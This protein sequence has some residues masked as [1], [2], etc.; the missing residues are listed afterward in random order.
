MYLL[1]SCHRNSIKNISK[2]AGKALAG[3]A[4][5]LVGMSGGLVIATETAEAAVQCVG[6]P[7]THI[8]GGGETW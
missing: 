8:G 6:V 4:L 1:F 7:Y 5:G 2:N 3:L